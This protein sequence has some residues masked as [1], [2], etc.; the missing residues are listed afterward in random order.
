MIKVV[1]QSK[2]RDQIIGAVSVSG[3]RTGTKMMVVPTLGFRSLRT[4]QIDRVD[5]LDTL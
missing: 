4:N 2:G 3:P 1:C 5:I